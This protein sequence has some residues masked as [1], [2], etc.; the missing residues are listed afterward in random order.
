MDMETVSFI[1]FDAAIKQSQTVTID[2]YL[3]KPAPMQ[4]FTVEC[5]VV[6]KKQQKV[7]PLGIVNMRCLKYNDLE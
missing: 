7:C 3:W 5:L 1:G 2:L 6:F 4:G